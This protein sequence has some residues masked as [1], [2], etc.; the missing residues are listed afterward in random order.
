MSKRPANSGPACSVAHGRGDARH[1]RRVGDVGRLEG[2]ALE[3]AD[4]EDVVLGQ[5]IDDGRSDPRLPRRLRVVPLVGPVDREQ[6]DSLELI[7]TT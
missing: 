2:A 6:V 1:V 3:E 4:D 5:R 7:R